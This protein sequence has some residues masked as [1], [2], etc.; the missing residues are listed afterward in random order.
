V[1][2]GIPVTVVPVPVPAVVT[3]P[4]VLSSVHVPDAGSPLSATLPVASMHVGWVIRPTV[5]ADGVTGWV[6]ITTF[7]DDT[8]LQPSWL[9]TVYV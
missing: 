9:V 7:D 3:A 8:E 2:A 6:L 4:G 5:G 1:P